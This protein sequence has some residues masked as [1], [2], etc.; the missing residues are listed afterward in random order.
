[1]SANGGRLLFTRNIGNIVMDVSGVSRHVNALGGPDTITI[2]DLSSTDVQ[3]VN[4]I[5]I[6]HRGTAATPRPTA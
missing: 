2:G 3:T 1:M 5:S 4:V 6:D